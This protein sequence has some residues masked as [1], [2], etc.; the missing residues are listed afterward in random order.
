LAIVNAGFEAPYF[1]G[2][3]P[4]QYAGDALPT[5][6]PVGAPPTG[7]QSYGAIGGSAYVGVLNPGVMAIEPL[8]TYFPAG[9]PEGDNVR[10]TF[11]DGHA[12]G[13]EFGFEQTLAAVLTARTVYT[14]TVEVGNIASGTS[15]VQPYASYGFFDLR[16]FPGYRVELLAG[17]AT[18]A[19]DENLLRP[20]EGTFLPTTVRMI[21]GETH[22]QLGAPLGV[23]LVSLNQQDV[24]DPVVDLEVDFDDVQLDGHAARNRRF[25]CGR[26]RRWKRPGDP[27]DGKFRR[28]CR[29]R[30]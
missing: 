18:I 11:N 20:H 30:C 2:N 28:L 27:S 19:A 17:E 21:V 8:A 25:R 16:G 13:V 29:R 1:G 23:R 4:P 15:A 22:A 26:R 10:L 6:F 14:L 3:L 7:W 5:A 9:A 24:D 12:G